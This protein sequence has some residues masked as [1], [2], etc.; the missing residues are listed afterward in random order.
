M[1]KTNYNNKHGITTTTTTTNNNQQQPT[2]TTTTTTTNN[3]NKQPLIKKKILTQLRS[4]DHTP[5]GV[6]SGIRCSYRSCGK[7]NPSKTILAGGSSL[8]KISYIRIPTENNL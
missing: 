8:N 3:N 6:S 1:V 4:K 5:L 7:R 2:T